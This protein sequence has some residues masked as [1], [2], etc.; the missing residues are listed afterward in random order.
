MTPASA[1]LSVKVASSID[2]LNEIKDLVRDQFLLPDAQANYG[3]VGSAA[4]VETKLREI[5]AFLK[6]QAS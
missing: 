3:H 5:R 4:E 2:L 6:G 1:R